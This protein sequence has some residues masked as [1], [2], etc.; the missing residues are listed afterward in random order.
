M[1][2]FYKSDMNIHIYIC[3]SCEV[4]KH[5]IF[6]QTS[7]IYSYIYLFEFWKS[8]AKSPQVNSKVHK[9]GPQGYSESTQSQRK[10]PISGS[11]RHSESTQSQCKGPR[12][13]PRGIVIPHDSY[14]KVHDWVRGV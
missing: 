5:E 6:L 13:G 4:F 9:V 8:N 11:A 12:L 3:L 7:H 10:G 2:Y 14:T 1:K